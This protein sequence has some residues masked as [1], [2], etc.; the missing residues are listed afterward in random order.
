MQGRGEQVRRLGRALV[1]ADDLIAAAADEADHLVNAIGRALEQ[2]RGDARGQVKPV[3]EGTVA[4]RRRTVAAQVDRLTVLQ[5]GPAPVRVDGHQRVARI[6]VGVVGRVVE[7]D[8][9]PLRLG[10]VAAPGGQP[11]AVPVVLGEQQPVRL[12]QVSPV[13]AAVRQVER[14]LGLAGERRGQ[15]HDAIA[16]LRGH[17]RVTA[18][19]GF[20][21][22]QAGRCPL[23]PGH[24]ARAGRHALARHLIADVQVGDD[25]FQAARRSPHLGGPG[26]IKTGH[27]E[28]ERPLQPLHQQMLAVGR[29]GEMPVEAGR[30]EL[31][32]VSGDR[33]D[34]QRDAGRERLERVFVGGGAQQVL[35]R[36]HLRALPGRLLDVRLDGRLPDGSR[37]AGGAECQQRPAVARPPRGRARRERVAAEYVPDNQPGYLAGGARLGV[38]DP[39]PDAVALIDRERQPP[40]VRCPDRHADLGVRRERQR[41]QRPVRQPQDRQAGQP[42]DPLTAAEH[43]VDA[44]PGQR[45][46]GPG[47]QADRG[48]WLVM[49]QR[50]EP[51]A[52]RQHGQRGRRGIDNGDDVASGGLVRHTAILL[53]VL[54]GLIKPSAAQV[55][56]RGSGS[57]TILRP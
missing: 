49:H 57:L 44:Q 5:D 54:R 3:Q 34:P 21:P 8:L 51:A 56:G 1:P 12:V 48:M 46:V 2:P 18:V 17:N 39:D 52:R 42:P 9:V 32:L 6:G 50:H 4:V 53:T 26:E 30:P 13:H 20:H 55:R 27:A 11:P 19:Q 10:Q 41:P 22:E 45:K 35:E 7:Q 33:V 14:R 38:S 15:P 23:L 40:P 37:L 31:A 25:P 43:R 29:F 36:R 47:Q 28:R 16:M 24:L